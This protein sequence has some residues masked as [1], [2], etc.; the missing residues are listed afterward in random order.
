[1]FALPGGK[2]IW[3]YS[4]LDDAFY[5]VHVI[6]AEGDAGF[7]I[8][9]EGQSGKYIYGYGLT[10]KYIEWDGYAE[11]VELA[12]DV[13]DVDDYETTDLNNG[14]ISPNG[15][16]YTATK[17]EAICEQSAAP[18]GSLYI[19]TPGQGLAKEISDRFY[20]PNGM[21]WKEEEESFFFVDSCLKTIFKYS[22]DPVT[23]AVSKCLK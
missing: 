23:G 19:Y 21:V 11:E 1:M 7:V 10:A 5:G 3:R 6:D 15:Q 2:Q 8:P 16:L 18:N 13:F 14:K 20:A 9:V 12:G 22:W 17:R 4:E